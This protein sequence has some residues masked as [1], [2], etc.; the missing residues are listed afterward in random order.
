[1]SD[2]KSASQVADELVQEAYNKFQDKNHTTALQLCQA[3]LAIYE[4]IGDTVGVGCTLTNIG[5]IYRRQ[6]LESY[7]E[8][9]STVEENSNQLSEEIVKLLSLPLESEASWYGS[10]RGNIVKLPRSE[11][12]DIPPQKPGN[13]FKNTRAG[14]PDDSHTAPLKDEP[15]QPDDSAVAPF[16]PLFDG[17]DDIPHAD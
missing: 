4:G 5:N 14:G 2:E 8:A 3:A 12:I 13:G 7:E 11:Q 9:R 15:G 17:P 16:K 10:D 6:A 1:M